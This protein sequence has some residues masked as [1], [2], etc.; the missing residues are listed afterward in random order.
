MA[1]RRVLDKNMN[2]SVDIYEITTNQI[3]EDKFL[4]I[5][6]DIL[7]FLLSWASPL[8]LREL[9]LHLYFKYDP[10]AYEKDKNLQTGMFDSP[11]IA[12]TFENR[13]NMG[14]IKLPIS[15]TEESERASSPSYCYVWE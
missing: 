14:L 6:S 10:E 1:F 12:D 15:V 2:V 8:T 3:V 11:P 5:L 4:Q 9:A 13:S 7:K